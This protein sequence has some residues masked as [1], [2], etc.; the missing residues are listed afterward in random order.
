MLDVE[1]Q[2]ST[3]KPETFLAAACRADM[4]RYKI[5]IAYDG[6]NYAGWQIQQN[7]VTIQEK[8]QSALGQLDG[9]PVIAHASGR[10]DA[11]VHAQKQVAHFDLAQPRDG[12]TLRRALNAMLP[13]DIRILSARRV[14]PSFHA[15]KSAKSKEYRYFIWNA[16]IVPPYYRHCRAHVRKPL[17]VGAMA[18]AARLLVGE[19]DFAAFAANP[20]REVDSTIRK[21]SELTIARRGPEIV[22][23]AMAN[24]FLYRMARSL[25]GLLIRVGEGALNPAEAETILASRAR[26]A[27]VPTAPAEGLFLWNVTY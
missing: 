19:R 11:G 21:L 14:P 1:R 17:D 25:A 20:N 24:G 10:T 13:P 6:T 9:G 4:Q 12:E 16:E 22:I 2:C 26:T 8:L 23:R 15:R 18:K 5:E 3:L 27:R 7:G